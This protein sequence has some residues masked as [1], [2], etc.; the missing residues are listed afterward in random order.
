MFQF[1]HK[2]QHIQRA[3]RNPRYSQVIFAKNNFD[4]C[5][6]QIGRKVQI[7]HIVDA[8]KLRVAEMNVL[9]G[10]MY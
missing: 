6:Y 8:D 7:S 10:L 4:I 3:K 2:K 5:I 9:L 1:Y